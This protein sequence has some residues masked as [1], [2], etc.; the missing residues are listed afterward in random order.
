MDNHHTG[1]HT[2][3]T[4]CQPCRLRHL[5]SNPPEK[6]PPAS[7]DQYRFH[8]N[9]L[10]PYQVL[11]CPRGI[12]GISHRDHGLPAPTLPLLATDSLTTTHKL[13]PHTSLH[14]PQVVSDAAAVLPN[15]QAL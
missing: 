7:D 2:T 11:C 1:P 12:S 13:L 10:F 14:P 6:C 15:H 4:H 3:P 8:H 5:V 9:S